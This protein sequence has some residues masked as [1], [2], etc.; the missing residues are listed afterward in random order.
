[1]VNLHPSLEMAFAV[2]EVIPHLGARPGDE[3]IIRPS[4]PDF[5]IEVRRTF[6]LE[7]LASIPD[8]CV[9]MLGAVASCAG[10]ASPAPDRPAPVPAPVDAPRERVLPFHRSTGS[11]VA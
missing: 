7:F 2:T 10:P 8:N 5:P 3:I 11:R 4:D 1:M 9:R 6:P